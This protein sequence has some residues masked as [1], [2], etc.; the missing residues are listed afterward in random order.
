MGVE[1]WQNQMLFSEAVR[2]GFCHNGTDMTQAPAQFLKPNNEKYHMLRV[3]DKLPTT[4]GCLESVSIV[5]I[6]VAKGKEV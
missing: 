1:L 5:T 6:Y 4:L 2:R 3:V